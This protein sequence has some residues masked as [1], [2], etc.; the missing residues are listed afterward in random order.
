MV[1]MN[2]IHLGLLSDRIPILFPVIGLEVQVGVGAESLSAGSFFDLPRLSEAIGHPVL[3]W[4]DVKRGRFNR[5]WNRTDTIPHDDDELLGCWSIVQTFDQ[6][7]EPIDREGGP[8][9]LHL[10]A[11]YTAVP[12]T[13]KL[14][15][16]GEGWHT[17]FESLS[18]LMSPEGR[19][20]A[21]ALEPSLPTYGRRPLPPTTPRPKPD[22]HLTCFDN[23]YWVWSKF[24][25][26]WEQTP[27]PTWDAV[28]T[29]L[30]FSKEADDITTYYLQ[31]VLGLEA[32]QQIPPFISIHARHSDFR[33]LCK[34]PDDPKSCY[35]PLSEYAQHVRE[36][37]S[38]LVQLHGPHSPLA[39]V[40]EVILMSDETDPE[41]WA[42]VESMGWRQTRPYEEEI[43]RDYGRRWPG[44]VDSIILSR[45]AAFIGTSQS[46]MSI[47]AVKSMK[48]AKAFRKDI[49]SRTISTLVDGICEENDCDLQYSGIEWA[50]AA[51]VG[52]LATFRDELEAAKAEMNQQLDNLIAR[53]AR[54]LNRV[55]SSIHRLPVE[56]LVMIFEEF[57]PDEPHTDDNTSLFDLLLICRTWYDA[58]IGSPQLWGCVSVDMPP[59]I[60]SLVLDRSRFHPIS[61][62]WHS[63]ASPREPT[64]RELIKLLDL[65]IENSTRLRQIDI[66]APRFSPA[67]PRNLLQ[68]P[69]LALTSLQ[70]RVEP[71]GSEVGSNGP[72]DEFTLLEGPKLQHLSLSDV[73]T[74]LN[75]PRLSNLI[76]LT[77]ARSSVPQSPED[78]LRFLS[79][80]QHLEVLDIQDLRNR[81]GQ[82]RASPLVLLQHL[83]K[84]VLARLPSAYSAAILASICAPLC[85]DVE[86]RDGVVSD[87]P[88]VEALDAV[89]WRPGND[90]AAWLVGRPGSGPGRSRLRVQKLMRWIV[91]KDVESL[92][93]CLKL[94]FAR[95]DV[96]QL[97]ARLGAAISQLPL[98]PAIH[99]YE[100]NIYSEGHIPVDLLPWSEVVES[101][102]IEGSNPCRS[103]LQQLLQRHGTG[104]EGVDWVC[105][106]L[107]TLQLTYRSNEEEDMAL[108][109]G[110]LLSL[111]RQ[112][113][114]GEDSSPGGVRPV[115]FEVHCK[116]CNFPNLWSLEDEILSI[117]PSFKLIDGQK[118]V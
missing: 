42:E 117:L 9:F 53:L 36:L 27:S 34:N 88:V 109:G 15:G 76:T 19:R 74:P 77:L 38:E 48:E 23:L 68:S 43:A 81:T 56:V 90:Q 13:V 54:R 18:H 91:V 33:N 21:F 41:W 79:S 57:E 104:S 85:A 16:T 62:N 73:T 8:L 12:P 75:H 98:P 4:Q 107:S 29:H 55:T 58:I 67:N 114:S 32:D 69:T 93:G 78:L 70:V 14:A 84:L 59:K 102:S 11:Q 95:S 7:K 86:V 108:D 47:I 61:L 64:T 92:E 66:H 10:D 17:S 63:Y 87:D 80:S 111:V 52:Q 115:L 60:A 3:D 30:H 35:T 94:E 101:L 26:E 110:A 6:S 2:L 65:A 116:K 45:G 113:W 100:M 50:E 49:V 103:V 99:L 39:Q 1:W 20:E 112:R 96:P 5:P 44:I 83:K 40:K 25:W 24:V 37:T 89:I 22:H 82:I 51:P 46:T 71:R 106:R 31:K 118:K 97:M 72:L 105:R 28:G